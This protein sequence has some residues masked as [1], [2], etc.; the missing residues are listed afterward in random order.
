MMKIF[1]GISPMIVKF[2]M[3]Q[4]ILLLVWM[5]LTKAAGSI[6]ICSGVSQNLMHFLPL[7]FY[8]PVVTGGNQG[9]MLY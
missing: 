2:M 8:S 9:K 7:Q 4:V 5:Y 1:Y 6:I 3:P